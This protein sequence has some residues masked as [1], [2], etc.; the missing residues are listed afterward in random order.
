[1][2]GARGRA[3]APEDAYTAIQAHFRAWTC[4]RLHWVPEWE[5]ATF[6]LPRGDAVLWLDPGLAFVNYDLASR[7]RFAFRVGQGIEKRA[8]LL[9]ARV[10][11]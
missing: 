4:G 7:E 8:Q 9:L 5:R 6:R 3:T 1:M 11:D 10:I 2:P